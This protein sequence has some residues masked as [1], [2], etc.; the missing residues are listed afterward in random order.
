[1]R[2]TCPRSTRLTTTVAGGRGSVSALGVD[3]PWRARVCLCYWTRS[4]HGQVAARK[5]GGNRKHAARTRGGNVKCSGKDAGRKWGGSGSKNTGKRTRGGNR[6]EHE[7]KGR[8]EDTGRTRAASGRREM[9]GARERTR[10]GNGEEVGVKHGK[11]DAA[12]TRARTERNTG[13]GDAAR[14]R[15]GHGVTARRVQP[16]RVQLDSVVGTVVVSGCECYLETERQEKRTLAFI[17]SPHPR[18]G[19]SINR[20]SHTL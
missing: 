7:G 13:E 5:W 3:M 15:A 6:D 9:G 4:G 1:M 16:R 19:T 8:G 10:R 14:T 11:R 20:T 18:R 17:F 2:S 12:R